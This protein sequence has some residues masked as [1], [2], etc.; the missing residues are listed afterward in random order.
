MR[1]L[2]DPWKPH[3]SESTWLLR[4]AHVRMAGMRAP[5]DWQSA[6]LARSTSLGQSL[7]GPRF[8]QGTRVPVFVL[9]ADYSPRFGLAYL[10]TRK[11][12]VK[13]RSWEGFHL[14]AIVDMSPHKCL[15]AD[16]IHPID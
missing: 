13:L 2:R 12:L 3:E 4:S 15:A 5:R 16:S 10:G 9:F 11:G 14:G 8:D 6:S 1:R 7:H